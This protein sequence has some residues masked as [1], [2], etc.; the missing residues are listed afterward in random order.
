[1]PSTNTKQIIPIMHC[2]NDDYV[3][4]ASVSFLSM[5]ENANPS[6][7]YKLFVLHTDISESHQKTLHSIVSRFDNASLEFIDIDHRFYDEFDKLKT[8][9][10]YTKEMFYKILAPQIFPHYNYIIITDVDVVFCGDIAEIYHC[11]YG[12]GG[13]SLMNTLPAFPILTFWIILCKILMERNFLAKSRVS[14]SLAEGF[15]V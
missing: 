4:P 14:Y 15:C 1:M 8:K 12:G 11:C 7:F 9:G 6:Y 10:H 5:L 13:R 3:I 2:F